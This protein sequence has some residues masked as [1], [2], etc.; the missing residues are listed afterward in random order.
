MAS[1]T[2]IRPTREWPLLILAV[3]LVCAVCIPL[4]QWLLSGVDEPAGGARWT[5][6]RLGR[7]FLGPEQIASYAAFVWASFILLGRYRE[8]RRQRRAFA[9]DL[10][11]KRGDSC[12]PLPP[13]P[14]LARRAN[15]AP[16]LARRANGSPLS[17]S[18][19]GAG[20]GV[21]SP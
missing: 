16:S 7:L 10:L 1:P 9:L 21:V 13:A 19:R 6:E 2:S 11:R 20:G 8:V 4:W 5:A 3:A 18:G 15:G 17:A 14:S 12:L